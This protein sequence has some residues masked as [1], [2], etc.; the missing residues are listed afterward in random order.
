MTD[1]AKAAKE[2]PDLDALR[3]AATALRAED[4]DPRWLANLVGA[5]SGS[6]P[7]FAALV[8]RI[9]P[10]D[11]RWIV[12]ELCR[13]TLTAPGS[14]LELDKDTRVGKPFFHHGDLVVA[15]DLR[16]VGPF[17]VTGSVTVRNVFT[18]SGPDSAVMIGDGLRARAVYTDGE[19][20]VS[21]T[22]SAEIVYCYYNDHTLEA[23][24][25]EAGLVI[26]DDHCVLAT[27]R[28]EHHFD[29]DT[30]RQG[31]GEGVQDRLRELLAPE[32]FVHEH[33]D[34]PRMDHRLLF[35]R[36]HQGLEVLRPAPAHP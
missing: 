31:Y 11:D 32:V 19:M 33:D 25:I 28:A 16:V 3:A 27:V 24:A 13:R 8:H 29:M 35:E 2:A 9:V 15:G 1:M 34:E 22:I 6:W 21:G 14:R 26:E 12:V 23:K 7:E 18:D 10:P 17:L 5:E 4:L 36:L 30:F 20:Y